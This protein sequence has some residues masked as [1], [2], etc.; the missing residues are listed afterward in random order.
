MKHFQLNELKSSV[1]FN[2]F[3]NLLSL[4]KMNHPIDESA[5]HGKSTSHFGGINTIALEPHQTIVHCH[6]L[7]QLQYKNHFQQCLFFHFF[8]EKFLSLKA[9]YK[10]QS[11]LHRLFTDFLHIMNGA[12]QPL[13]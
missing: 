9:I 13:N 4:L 10:I 5:S 2:D 12:I 11:N 3:Q 6:T 7:L 8:P 1:F